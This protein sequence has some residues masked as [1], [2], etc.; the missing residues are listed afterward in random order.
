VN[1]WLGRSSIQSPASAPDPAEQ[2]AD[3]ITALYQEHALSLIRMA[4]LMLGN[5]AAAEDVV[6]DAF[7][8]LYRHWDD[9]ASK[10]RAIGYVRSSVLNGC[11]TVLRRIPAREL[12]PEHHPISWS[13]EAVVLSSGHLIPLPRSPRISFP[14]AAW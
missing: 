2:A 3:A 11:R 10:D 9:L 7:C 6:Q 1:Q 4:H 14:A 5:R 8:G 13:A 12:T